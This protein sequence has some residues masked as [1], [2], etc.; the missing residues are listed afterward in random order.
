[1]AI[2]PAVRAMLRTPPV[3]FQKLADSIPEGDKDEFIRELDRIIAHATRL[4]VYV[5]ERYGY[6]CGDQGHAQGVK[7][8]N[9]VVAAV[10]KALGY[11]G[12]F[13]LSF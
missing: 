6:G 4:A 11:H 9:K 8:S 10:R 13:G 1:M 12:T 5:G 3:K 2:S 7:K